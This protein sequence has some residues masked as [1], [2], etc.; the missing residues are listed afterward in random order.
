METTSRHEASGEIDQGAGAGSLEVA[1]EGLLDGIAAEK[2]CE[3]RESFFLDD[4]QGFVI[5]ESGVVDIFAMTDEEGN[6]PGRRIHITRRHGGILMSEELRSAGFPYRLMAVPGSDAQVVRL[7]SALI[8][9]GELGRRGVDNL[10]DDWLLTLSSVA[11]LPPPPAPI[12]IIE[13]ATAVA[14]GKD[15][16]VGAAALLWCKAGENLW[17]LG[18]KPGTDTSLTQW[19]PLSKHLWAIAKDASTLVPRV[20][21]QLLE[22]G[23]LPESLAQVHA[24]IWRRVLRAI[25]EQQQEAISVAASREFYDDVRLAEIDQQFMDL[26]ASHRVLQAA[27]ETFPQALYRACAEAAKSM[28]VSVSRLRMGEETIESRRGT[29]ERIFGDSGVRIREVGLKGEWWRQDAGHLI[30]FSRQETPL[31]LI[32]NGRGTYVLFDGYSGTRSRVDPE[33]GEAINQE[34][35]SLCRPLP[36]L[37][38]S[39]MKLVRF[40]LRGQAAGI[41]QV[42]ASAVLPALLGLLAPMIIAYLVGRVIPSGAF[43]ELFQYV[44]LLVAIAFVSSIFAISHGV[45]IQR[46]RGIAAANVQSA[47]WSRL[48]SLPM[49]FFREFTVGDLAARALGVNAMDVVTGAAI[50]AVF[51]SA[52]SLLSLAYMFYLD[53][54]LALLSFLFVLVGL[55][56]LGCFLPGQLRLQKDLATAAGGFSG[57]LVQLLVGISYLRVANAERRAFGH[58]ATDYATYSAKYASLRRRMYR[59]DITRFLLSS[60]ATLA[61]LI[62]VAVSADGISV[63]TFV[64]FGAAF[65]QFSTGMFGVLG[66]LGVLTA[67]APVYERAKPIL[68]ATPESPLRRLDPG[69]LSGAV[70][71]TDVSFR[72]SREE[73]EALADINLSVPPGQF[74]AVCGPSGSGKSTLLRLFLGLLEPTRGFV[75]YDNKNLANLNIQLLRRQLGVVMQGDEL[76]AGTIHQNIVSD[77]D[78]KMSEVWR[79]AHSVGLSEEIASFPMRMHT[80]V[81][82]G[83]SSLSAGQR[84]KILLARA[85]LRNPR[86]LLLDEAT[87]ALDNVS[88]SIVCT[89]LTNSNATRIVIAH[90]LSTIVDADRIVV[91]DR[92]RIVQSGTYSALIRQEGI[93]AELARRQQL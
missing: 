40:A 43:G 35:Y 89:T 82:Q 14:L 93:F 36:R 57:K 51:S 30:G 71:A 61:L 87:S 10:I 50:S 22:E 67:I 70:D 48:L 2:K 79:I 16:A 15:Q 88:Q 7:D 58:W 60:A 83:G 53:W 81:S 18:E 9:S 8:H 1:N 19:L 37:G 23:T 34:A 27:S 92:G 47:I 46:L 64:A 39:R 63:G 25:E 66:A 73:P 42:I 54:Q 44:L 77:R 52:F 13:N 86:I 17:P 65:Q 41:W 59:A 80:V 32:P 45:V 90:R 31:A 26:Y 28:G 84:Q 72:Y 11:A 29:L 85:L 49:K 6:A 33:I 3:L 4:R 12:E 91:M 20:T 5:I 55:V 76:S 75:M 21:Q 24:Y 69:P 38:I 56:V 74:I 78:V 68:M 62:S